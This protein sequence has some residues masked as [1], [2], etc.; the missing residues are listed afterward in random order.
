VTEPDSQAG[1]QGDPTDAVCVRVEHRDGGASYVL[2]AFE[3]TFGLRRR[4]KLGERQTVA[5]E[6]SIF[7]GPERS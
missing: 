6:R 5:G 2:T 3:R 4:W 7:D 1:E